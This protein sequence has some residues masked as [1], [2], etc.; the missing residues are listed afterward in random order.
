MTLIGN[1]LWLITGGFLAAFGWFLAGIFWHLTI[2]GI[3]W[4]RQCF[5]FA[6]LSLAP[7][8]KEVL[9]GGGA[10]SLLANVIWLLGSGFPMACGHLLA[11]F[12]L[13]LTIVGIPFGRQHFKLAQLALFPFGAKVIPLRARRI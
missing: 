9:P 3:P 6:R 4:G 2:I 5:K 8:G 11:G 12:L 1:F 7:F 10:P 13:C